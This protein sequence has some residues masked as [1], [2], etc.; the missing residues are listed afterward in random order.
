MHE[1]LII[2][3]ALI[4]LRSSLLQPSLRQIGSAEIVVGEDGCRVFPNCRL[5][6]RNRACCIASEVGNRPPKHFRLMILGILLE[7]LVIPARSFG[8]VTQRDI[9]I[10]KF[11]LHDFRRAG[12]EACLVF[13]HSPGD[14]IMGNPEIA[15]VGVESGKICRLLLQRFHNRVN[16][17]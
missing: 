6:L 3:Y 14:L 12:Q 4:E 9:R 10:D 13:R 16:L 8:S 7:N 17:W 15:Q 1:L 11:L 5:Q 2:L